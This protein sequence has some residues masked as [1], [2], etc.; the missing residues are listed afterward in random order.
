AIT[1]AAEAAA[2]ERKRRR[3]TLRTFLIWIGMQ[4]S[5]VERQVALKA[6]TDLGKFHDGSITADVFY[7]VAV[8]RNCAPARCRFCGT[9]SN[10]ALRSATAW[11][12][13]SSAILKAVSAPSSIA[14]CS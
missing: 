6:P 3:E 4:V 2:L 1:P 9:L 10:R 5:L 8:A 11:W 12:S 13:C 14:P 7:S